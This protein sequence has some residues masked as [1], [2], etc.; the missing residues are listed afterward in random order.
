[1]VTHVALAGRAKSGGG[2]VNAIRRIRFAGPRARTTRRT[3][4]RV[5]IEPAVTR[6]RMLS[7]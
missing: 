1:M 2:D 3:A 5:L 6:V 7:L 4:A